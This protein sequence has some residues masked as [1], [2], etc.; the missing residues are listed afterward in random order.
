MSDVPV[1]TLVID[2]KELSRCAVCGSLESPRE[3]DL[4]GRAV[5]VCRTCYDLMVRYPGR[6]EVIASRF[7]SGISGKP[8]NYA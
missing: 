8:G 2:H 5:S 4:D 7:T 1:S 3:L 6:R